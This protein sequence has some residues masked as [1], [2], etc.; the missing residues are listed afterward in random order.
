MMAKDTVGHVDRRTDSRSAW[1]LIITAVTGI[2]FLAGCSASQHKE[3]TDKNVYGI[4]D[5]KQKNVTGQSTDFSIEKPATNLRATVQS[6]V[7][8]LPPAG[9]GAD[10][11]DEVAARTLSLDEALRLAPT[12]SRD[13]QYQ[14]EELYLSGLDLVLARHEWSPLFSSMIEGGYTWDD[15]E[16]T[17]DGSATLKL[18]KKLI[19]GA[20]TAVSY[21]VGAIYFLGSDMRPE[22]TS[23]LDASFVQPLL[24]GAGRAVAEENLK[25]SER[26]VI[27]QVRAFIRYQKKFSIDITSAY[28]NVLRLADQVRNEWQ[29]YQN[30]VRNRMRS[31]FLEQAG[32]TPLF[33]VD[34]ARQAEL[35]AHN[36]WVQTKERYESEMDSF[37]TRIGLPPDCAVALDRGVLAWIESNR[38][39]EHEMDA[40]NTSEAVQIGL[41][42]RLDLMTQR[43]KRADAERKIYV[44]RNGLLPQLDLVANA[45]VDGTPPRNWDRMQ[46]HRGTYST[47]LRLDPGLDR[48]KE[49]ATYRAAM[50]NLERAARALEQKEDEVRTDIREAIRQLEGQRQSYDIQR[51]SVELAA[52]RVASVSML[53]EA[54]RASMRDLLEAQDDLVSAQNSLT[55]AL[56]SQTMA[57][58]QYKYASEQFELDTQGRPTD[59]FSQSGGETAPAGTSP[60]PSD[61]Q[62]TGG[63][64]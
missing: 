13:Y 35:R 28:L 32:R 10:M 37:R 8:H 24:R 33:E 26:D 40:L 14:K 46:F 30:L 20:S 4:V 16:E 39:A 7:G 55:S 29:N 23:S 38:P 45:S 42:N 64:E 25:Q 18:Q 22:I 27:Y 12:S 17:V 19:T 60:T 44:A 51:R 15:R 49:A 61:K 58:L 36:S 11:P 56:I 48:V 21:S 63:T 57:W 34:Q 1:I 62:P 2:P 50:V 47:G 41:D 5:A 43:D 52:R 31:E 6:D 53:M 54:G 59:L 3:K 9:P